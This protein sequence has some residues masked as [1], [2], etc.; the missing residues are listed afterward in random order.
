M[1]QDIV[2]NSIGDDIEM[3]I[4]TK[5]L[6]GDHEGVNVT[7]SDDDYDD[8]ST[9]GIIRDEIEGQDYD[10]RP[11]RGRRHII[12]VSTGLLI[13]TIVSLTVFIVANVRS[14]SMIP[15]I[16]TSVIHEQL[17]CPWRPRPPAFAGKKGVAL[18][19]TDDEDVNSPRS[20]ARNVPI[21]QS[22]RPYWNY[23]W[24]VVRSAIQPNDIEWVPMVWGGHNADA[25]KQRIDTYVAPHIQ[26]GSVKRI[27]GFNEPDSPNQSNMAVEQALEIW[28][29][30][31]YANVSVISPSC[32]QPASD[33]MKAFMIT[34]TNTC[35]RVDWVA[36]HWYGPANFILFRNTI[37]NYYYLYGKRPIVITEFGVADFKTTTFEGNGNTR[38]EVL[39]FMKQALPW[40]ES[41]SWVVG[42][43]WFSFKI[44]DMKGWTSALYDDSAQLTPLG[45]FYASVRKE[46]PYGDRTIKW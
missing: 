43:A 6:D 40:L 8:V 9:D 12:A 2:K 11:K 23:G 46:T 27:F 39:S 31:E 25:V 4:C 29:S 45:N 17:Y 36:V 30:L 24:T 32:A 22:L 37:R 42:Y 41:R 13:G 33:W 26:N 19:L 35:Q 21:L 18:V 38:E 3:I 5:R 28:P 15:T 34:A 1:R 20:S 7:D 10:T 44:D 16:F 14:G